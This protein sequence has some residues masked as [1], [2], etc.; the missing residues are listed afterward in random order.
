MKTKIK[1]FW[2]WLLESE[3]IELL[4]TGLLCLVS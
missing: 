2:K 1:N 4:I 3:L